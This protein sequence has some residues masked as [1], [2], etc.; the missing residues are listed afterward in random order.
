MLLVEAREAGQLVHLVVIHLIASL[1][2][3]S[4]NGVRGRCL[5]DVGEVGGEVDCDSPAIERRF[6]VWRRHILFN[7]VVL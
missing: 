2:I 4:G 6:D 1:L 5:P 3:L 7:F